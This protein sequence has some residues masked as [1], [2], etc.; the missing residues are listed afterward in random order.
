MA[1][2]SGLYWNDKNE[3]KVD[4]LGASTGVRLMSFIEIKN[5]SKSYG[6]VQVLQDINL[7]FEAQ[8]QYVIKGASG[9]GKSTLLYLVGGLDTASAGEIWI[10]GKNIRLF[11]DEEL[12]VYRNE[13]IGFVFQF[14]FLLPSMSCL[15]NI[16]LPGVIAGEQNEGERKQRALDLAKRLGVEHCLE[17][18]PYQIS[19][20]EQ[21]RVNI[22]RAVSMRPKL[23]LCDEPT[24]NLDS[25]NT[26]KVVEL[27]KELAVEYQATLISVTHDHEVASHFSEVLTLQ[28]GHFVKAD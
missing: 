20:G 11:S 21:Q 15:D 1:A 10:E 6:D 8:K 4:P 16:L 24:G 3:K 12:S 28:D 23:L 26:Q 2:F 9:S 17:K 13:N 14:H 7:N 5:L 18:F 25:L 22:I 27:L 19:G